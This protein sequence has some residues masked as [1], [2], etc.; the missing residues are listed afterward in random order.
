MLARAIPSSPHLC[1][2]CS[3]ERWSKGKWQTRM[4]TKQT[5]WVA[6]TLVLG[7]SVK[8]HVTV[9]DGWE[10]GR[11][12]LRLSWSG[13]LPFPPLPPPPCL[14]FPHLHNAQPLSVESSSSPARRWGGGPTVSPNSPS[15]CGWREGEWDGGQ[16]SRFGDW[17]GWDW[18]VWLGLAGGSNWRRE[19]GFGIWLGGFVGRDR[20]VLSS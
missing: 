3:R 5:R 14:S 4:N 15:G 8:R 2:A 13:D 19:R 11:G 20:G 18:R 7:I 16:R 6:R 9:G 17:D 10:E 1:F 12:N